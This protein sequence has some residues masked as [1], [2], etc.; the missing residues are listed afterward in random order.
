MVIGPSTA[1][2]YIF[3]SGSFKRRPQNSTLFPPLFG[4]Q[5]V[6]GISG[7]VGSDLQAVQCTWS[8]SFEIG[9]FSI[10]ARVAL[11][12]TLK[13][14]SAMRRHSTYKRNHPHHFFA[15]FSN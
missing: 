15:A 1:S 7:H 8:V 2:I 11:L 5:K 3:R 13:V 14:Q 9:A 4:L 6:F 10:I 12:K